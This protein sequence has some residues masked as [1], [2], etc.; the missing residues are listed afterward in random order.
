MK[1]KRMCTSLILLILTFSGLF[2]IA[3]A[4]DAQEV[5]ALL[6]ILGNDRD[7]AESV[8]KNEQ[9]MINML[10]Q[11]SH[12]CNVHL[13]LMYSKSSHEGTVSEKT[14]VNGRSEKPTTQEQDI[15]EAKQVVEWLSNLRPRPE[16]TVLIYFNG[17]GK[18]DPLGAHHLLFNPGVS[19]EDNLDRGKLSDVAG[20]H[21]TKLENS[22]HNI[23]FEKRRF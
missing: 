21:S 8:A 9:K 10:R 22:Y 19:P 23:T 13:T 5:H 7:I 18:M 15:I 3:T 1:T 6:I 2:G 12:H 17:Y 16:D 11:L 14:F 20:G 4:A